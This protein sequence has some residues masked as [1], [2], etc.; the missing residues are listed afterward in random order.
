MGVTW[1]ST[2]GLEGG[3][4]QSGDL[5]FAPHNPAKNNLSANPLKTALNKAGALGTRFVDLA[6]AVVAPQGVSALA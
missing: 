6:K 5:F 2:E 1:Q 4:L 3:R